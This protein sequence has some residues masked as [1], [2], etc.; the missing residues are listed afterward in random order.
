MNGKLHKIHKTGFFSLAR[1]LGLN[2][3]FK[4]AFSQ[5]IAQHTPI[6]YT[7]NQQSQQQIEM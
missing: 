2:L 1:F 4:H 6:E 3:V 5:S 7:T